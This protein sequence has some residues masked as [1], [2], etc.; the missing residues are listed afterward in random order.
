VRDDPDA[1][2]T[3]YSGRNTGSDCPFSDLFPG[4]C[5]SGVHA[6][7]KYR[8]KWLFLENNRYNRDLSLQFSGLLRVHFFATGFR[9]KKSLKAAG[10]PLV[11]A[12]AIT[13]ENCGFW[14]GLSGFFGRCEECYFLWEC[15]PEFFIKKWLLFIFMIECKKYE[16][17]IL[18]VIAI[19]EPVR[20]YVYLPR[21]FPAPAQR[22]SGLR[23]MNNPND[24]RF[25]ALFL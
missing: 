9:L 7:R 15:I 18:F 8:F 17:I 1:K 25:D 10:S 5:G 13:S 23:I 2:Y 3:R 12:N 24:L 21:V 20:V 11:P 22:F 4:S 16:C 19:R 14:Q 6:N